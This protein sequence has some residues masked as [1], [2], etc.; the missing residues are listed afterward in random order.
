M[1][2]LIGGIL[3]VTAAGILLTDKG[4]TMAKGFVNIFF[5]DVAKTPQG[6]NAIYTQAIDECQNDYNKADNNL[7]KIS[8]MLR[9]TEDKIKNIQCSI[10]N[11]ERKCEQLVKADRFEDAEII[12]AGIAEMEE[13]IVIYQNKAKELEPMLISAKQ[14]HTHLES[15]LNKLKKDKNI[16]VKQ[17]E[18]NKQQEELYND[19]DDLKNIKGS[20]KL[21]NSVKEE[22]ISSQE[23]TV[24]ARTVHENRH[25]TKVQR[26]N[27]NLRASQSS[28]KVEELKRKYNK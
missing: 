23:R 21:L 14:V 25:S 10:E 6:A 3:V 5:E 7:K 27:E 12:A 28:A 1:T 15:K 16:V 9:T 4:R 2:A 8:G 19:L 22:V 13:E 26:V 20:D 24:G 17:L 18:I 11:E